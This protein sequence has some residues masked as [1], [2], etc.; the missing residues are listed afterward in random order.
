MQSNRYTENNVLTNKVDPLH[1]PATSHVIAI[2]IELA[3]QNGI[4]TSNILGSAGLTTDS[5][6]SPETEFNR[7]Q[8][9]IVFENL[10]DLTQSETL[11]LQIGRAIKVSCLGLPGYTCRRSDWLLNRFPVIAGLVFQYRIS[12]DT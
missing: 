12:N 6:Y 10:F 5:L 7:F 11:G 1:I 8:E 3:R 4:N 9:L 2:A